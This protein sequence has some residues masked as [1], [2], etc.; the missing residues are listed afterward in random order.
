MMLIPAMAVQ[1]Q[2]GHRVYYSDSLSNENF[3]DGLIT[4]LVLT[5]GEPVFAAT[6]RTVSTQQANFERARFVRARL[7]GS[8][9]NNRK[10]FI[11][12]NGI[13]IAARMNAI[14]EGNSYFMMSGTT[15][16]SLSS[17]VPGGADILLMKASASGVP[18]NL[19]KIDLNGG[20]DE[21]LCTRRSFK[22]ASNFYTC[23]YSSLQG[24]SRAFV[25][26]HN[27]TL[28]TISWVRTFSLPCLSGQTGNAEAT[29]VIDDSLSNTVVVV[30]NVKSVAGGAPCQRAFIAKFAA[31]GTLQWLHFIS[32]GNATDFDFQSIRETGVAQQYV[33]TG[34]TTLQGL[35]KR[36]LLYVVNTSGAAP[37]TVVA[38]ALY[39]NG[40]TPNY[41][42]SSQYGYDVVTRIE[43][44]KK[45]YFIC[46]A[47]HYTG[48]TTD[49][50][51]FKTDANGVPLASRLYYGVGKEQ[52]NAID[53]V[54]SPGAAGNGIAAFGN[55]VK[56]LSAGAPTR[57]LCLLTKTY[58]NGVAGCAELA[59]NPQAQTLS[60]QYTSHT[61]STI[62]TYTKDSLTA[63][64]STVLNDKI[65]WAT[66]VASGSN[67]RLASQEDG[68]YSS[69]GLQIKAYPNPVSSGPFTLAVEAAKEERIM[70]RIFDA[71]GKL[72]EEFTEQLTSGNNALQFDAEDLIKG[73]YLV[74]VSGSSGESTTVRF[75]KM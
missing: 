29:A 63:Q 64:N 49:G 11:F 36:V 70:V 26:K 60:I 73:V 37:V 53:Y 21:A 61:A 15:T 27:N 42:V 7:G 23:G 71:T 33:I 52:F 67:T 69:G 55:Y 47:N 20:F 68:A 13:E 39:S 56:I 43:P 51:I 44:T 2:Y 25:M 65:C 30:G 19:F 45:E 1:A 41:P 57:S 38:K 10:Y 16:G 17:P 4:N 46:G 28:S 22:T 12:K 54:S 35:N 6:G 48:N 62:K 58:F 34:S 59:D 50:I 75:V 32:A 66:N 74:Q 14:S 18:S 5:S 40:P 24:V 8:V 72:V 9:Q 3:T 31:A